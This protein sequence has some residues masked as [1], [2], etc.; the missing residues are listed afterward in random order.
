MAAAS[1]VHGI[2]DDVLRL[3]TCTGQRRLAADRRI[4]GHRRF[5]VADP[6]RGTRAVGGF[7]GAIRRVR[8]PNQATAALP[9]VSTRSSHFCRSGF[10]RELLPYAAAIWQKLAAKAAPTKTHVFS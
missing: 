8:P 1:V 10:S 7:S 6:H 2:A 5:P 3:R 9:L 4:A